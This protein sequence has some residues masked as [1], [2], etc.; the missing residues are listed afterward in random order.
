M[1][2]IV[3]HKYTTHT[4]THTHTFSPSFSHILCSTHTHAKT[5]CIL[6]LAKAKVSFEQ[7]LGPGSF[8]VLHLYIHACFTYCMSHSNKA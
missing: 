3:D 5:A 6:K 2:L 7:K 4:H 1:S 8:F